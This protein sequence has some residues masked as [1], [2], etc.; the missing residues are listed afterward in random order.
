MQS[1]DNLTKNGLILRLTVTKLTCETW[2]EIMLSEQFS[3][4]Q[5][6]L[7]LN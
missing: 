3:H 7:T 1:Y 6:N 5:K 2:Q 4:Y